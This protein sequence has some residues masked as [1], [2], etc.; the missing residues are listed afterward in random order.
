MSHFSSSPRLRSALFGCL[1]AILL[2]A[3]SSQVKVA[4]AYLAPFLL[5]LATLLADR[6]P[7]EGLIRMSRVSAPRRCRPP[8]TSRFVLTEPRARRAPLLAFAEAGRAP[9]GSLWQL[10]PSS[11]ST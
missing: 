2:V 3:G 4:V 10:S 7:G 6:Y 1:P 11:I 8:S 5:L 9:P